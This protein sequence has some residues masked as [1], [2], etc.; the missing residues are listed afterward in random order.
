MDLFNLSMYVVIIS[1]QRHG[2]NKVLKKV[3]INDTKKWVVAFGKDKQIAVGGESRVHKS[4]VIGRV[5]ANSCRI[6]I[7]HKCFIWSGKLLRLTGFQP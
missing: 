2:H 6:F 4:T 1:A 5:F 3:Y 7:T